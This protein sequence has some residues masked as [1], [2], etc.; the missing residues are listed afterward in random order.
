MYPCLIQLFLP[1]RK[2]KSKFKN[3]GKK[4]ITAIDDLLSYLFSSFSLYERQ[5]LKFE[6]P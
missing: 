1:R 4:R 6:D 5:K 3:G 2:I